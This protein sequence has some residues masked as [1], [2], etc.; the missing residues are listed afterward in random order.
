MKIDLEIQNIQHVGHMKFHV[1]LSLNS[2]TCVV[3]KNGVGKTTLIKSLQTLRF[4]DTFTQ[5]SQPGIF[6]DDSFIK[7]TIDGFEYRFSYDANIRSLNSKDAIP[8]VIKENI[9]VELPMPYGQ[10]FSFFQTL[11]KADSEIRS[12]IVLEDYE[13]PI[14]LIDFLNSIYSTK[15]FNNLIKI[16]IKKNEYYCILLEDSRYIREDYL[17]SGEYLLISVYRK[18]K[19]QCKFIVIDEIDISLDAAAQTRL[20]EKL[21]K[22]CHIYQVNILFT[23]H[24]LALMKTLQNDEIFYLLENNGVIAPTPASYNYIKSILFGF[25]GW[26]RYILTEDELL[27]N[28][29]QHLINKN[30]PE[31]HFQYKII[32]IGG[33][34]SVVDLMRR[35]S[36]E[37]FFSEK[38]NVISI[39]DGDQAK[40]KHAKNFNNVHCIPFESVEKQIHSDYHSGSLLLLKSFGAIP[41]ME[42]KQLNK[43]FYQ[44][45]RKQKLMSE[46]EVFEYLCETYKKEIQLFCNILRKFLFLPET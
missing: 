32:Y 41:G 24:S 31:T 27:Q 25:K 17:S 6:K 22:F 9:D 38:T 36:E 40:E 14:E 12:N 33:G 5:T 21:R 4:A 29:I 30:L 37:E 18:I 28:L 8:N 34:S 2:L 16:K 7:Y 42:N 11:A 44:Y 13:R 43:Q 1:D 3:G 15:K 19:N 23:T 39:L 20:A 45:I 10:R 46:T 35:N 26:D